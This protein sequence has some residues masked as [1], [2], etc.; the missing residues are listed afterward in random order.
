M[1]EACALVFGIIFYLNLIELTVD[2]DLTAW[3]SL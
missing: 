3:L 1:K 2:V